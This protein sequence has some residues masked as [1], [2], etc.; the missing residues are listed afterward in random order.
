MTDD[1]ERRTRAPSDILRLGV[2]AASLIVVALLAWL[3]DETIVENVARTARG[4]DNVSGSVIA[5]LATMAEIL[6][7]ALFGG[8]LV[9]VI[10]RRQWFLLGM[11]MAA[12]GI[13]ILLFAL[14]REIY[15]SEAH[16]Q[17]VNESLALLPPGDVATGWG[18]AAVT[19]VVTAAAPWV[20]RRWRRAG[21]CLVIIVTIVRLVTAPVSFDTVVA[22]LAGWTAG[23]AAVVALGAPSRRPTKTA[24][25]EGLGAV[26]VPL[27]EIDPLSVDA[28]GS[29]PYLATGTDGGKLFVKALGE[30]ERSA[31]LMF[32]IYRAAQ[33]RHL[34][35]ERPFSSLRR[36]VEHEALVALAASGIG[37]RTPRFVTIATADPNGFVLAY[38]AIAGRSLD[39][40][41]PDEMT[42]D[43]LNAVWAQFAVLRL[44]RV[45]HR[46]LRLANVF[47]A[48]D[49]EVWIIDFGFAELAASDL[50]LANDLAEL[51]ASSTSRVGADRAVAAGVAA[52][53]GDA[54]RSALDRLQLPML[55]GATREAMK[56]E[57][58]LLPALREAVEAAPA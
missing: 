58:D 54:L 27:A 51:L 18:L 13:G 11:T 44:H 56:A 7:L 55:A 36:M 57:P 45:A 14:V 16:I 19:A 1:T 34:G 35:D 5:L 25:A 30:D 48:D 47:L 8:G 4:L 41:E 20:S 50:L 21:W 28:R 2:A 6:G 17:R 49:G 23:A 32:R 24:I 22:L 10:L 26:G 33:P 3:F 38:E 40:L 42:D 37:V 52:V 15:N 29:T 9:F 43:V 31:D 53:G 12:A 46:D 39:Q